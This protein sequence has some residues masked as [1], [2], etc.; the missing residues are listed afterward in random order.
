MLRDIVGVAVVLMLLVLTG[1]FAPDAPAPAAPQGQSQAATTTSANAPAAPPTPAGSVTYAVAKVIDGDTI[2]VSIHGAKETVRLIGIDTPETVDPRK[3]MQCFG[4]EASDKTKE[5]LA[6]QRVVLEK[7]PSQG[8]YDKYG[9][10]LAYVYRADGLF[11]NEYL[12]AQGFAHEYTYDA[13]YKYQA[14]FKAAQAEARLLGRG[15]WAPNACSAFAPKA[16]VAAPP[17]P[18][19]GSGGYSC[20]SNLYNCADFA[21]HAEAQSVY[22]ACGGASNDVHWLDSD[23]DGIACESLP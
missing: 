17:A 22:E 20:S 18:A 2:S 21:T 9:R 19:A 23:K 11:V 16:S 15:L 5:L 14:E 12:V 6:G 3:P 10:T 8:E 13:P 7:D 1:S 4:K